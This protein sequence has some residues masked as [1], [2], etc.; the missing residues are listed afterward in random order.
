M[1]RQLFEDSNDTLPLSE[2]C[3]RTR[4]SK[5]TVCRLL[6][7][8]RNGEDITKKPKRGRKPKYYPALL[9]RLSTDLCFRN[10]PIR[11]AQA[12][13]SRN[14]LD[15]V[16]NETLPIVSSSTIFR[17]VTDETIMDQVEQVPLSFTQCTV[18]GEHTNSEVNKALQIQRW[19]EMDQFQ[20]A[21]YTIVFVDETFN[22]FVFIW[23]L[24]KKQ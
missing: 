24:E 19:T 1:T 22:S 3:A 16:A 8:L 17:Y 9:K 7:R 5:P 18:R 11:R 10:M 2:F 23:C 21:G 6:K 15:S 12:E 14:Y 4:L 20:R 13:L